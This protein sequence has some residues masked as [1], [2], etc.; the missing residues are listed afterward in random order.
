MGYV[1]NEQSLLSAERVRTIGF[2]LA[3]KTEG[4]FQLDV[5]AVRAI[6]MEKEL[7]NMDA[8]P[9]RTREEEVKP[10]SDSV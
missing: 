1:Q 3:D 9:T 6:R 5:K 10:A 7:A 4:P 2:L 8:V